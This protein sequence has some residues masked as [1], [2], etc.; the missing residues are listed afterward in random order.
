M[1]G[2]ELTPPADSDGVLI[3]DRLGRGGQA[4][5]RAAGVPQAGEV[6]QGEV[7]EA[8][9]SD[10]VPGDKVKLNV[11]TTDD[12]GKPISAVV[13]VTRHATTACWR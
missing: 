9:K 7:I 12:D 5:G 11:T 3:A 6:D 2:V 13:G 4:A 1:A 10:Y 8:D